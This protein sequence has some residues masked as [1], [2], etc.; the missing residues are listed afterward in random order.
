M[1]EAITY[2]PYIEAIKNG[3]VGT[4]QRVVKLKNGRERVVT[5]KKNVADYIAQIPGISYEGI[6]AMADYF[7]V[8]LSS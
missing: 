4:E 7:G 2:A 8:D 1:A 5:V 6:A 3:E